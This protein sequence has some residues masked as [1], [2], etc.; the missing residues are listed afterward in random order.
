MS[1]SKFIPGAGTAGIIGK[2]K[3][4]A[5]VMLGFAMLLAILA[6]VSG[7]GYLDFVKI[8]E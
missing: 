7:T 2:I 5:K 8:G 4:R 3:I 1:L 6:A